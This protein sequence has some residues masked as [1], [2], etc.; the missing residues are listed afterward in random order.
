M[1]QRGTAPQ[2]PSPARR[3]RRRLH[4]SRPRPQ[5]LPAVSAMRRMMSSLMADSTLSAAVITVSDSCSRRTR[6]DRSGPA[7]AQFLEKLK[8]SVLVREV[9]PDDTIHCEFIC[10]DRPTPVQKS[11]ALGDR[12]ITRGEIILR[13]HSALSCDATKTSASS[14]V[15]LY[16]PR[17]SARRISVGGSHRGEEIVMTQN[18]YSRREFLGVTAAAATGS[19]AARTITMTPSAR[20]VMTTSISFSLRTAGAAVR[21]AAFAASRGA[22]RR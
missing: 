5:R 2:I 17:Y 12:V 14:I 13:G 22:R 11:P 15:M 9:V 20:R 19:M 18:N 10:A 21:S 4:R 3:Q 16:H 6:E 1:N 8:F 7:V